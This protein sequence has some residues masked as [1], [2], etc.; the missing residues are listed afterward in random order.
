MMNLLY[1]LS[2]LLPPLPAC[3]VRVWLDSA[4][5]DLP[6]HRI[7]PSIAEVVPYQTI[8][9]AEPPSFR[10]INSQS[11]IANGQCPAMRNVDEL[12]NVHVRKRSVLRQGDQLI[13][14]LCRPHGHISLRR[15]IP[16][17]C[18]ITLTYPARQAGD[19][20]A[21]VDISSSVDTRRPV[22]S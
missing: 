20:M 22:S 11:P 21:V 9:W 7:R 17:V 3:R 15:R 5:R 16:D 19:M 12:L 8:N 13:C 4:I 10:I 6:C 18:A 14:S 1:D 2:F